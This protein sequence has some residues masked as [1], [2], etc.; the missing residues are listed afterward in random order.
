[1]SKYGLT[2]LAQAFAKAGYVQEKKN[3]GNDV[4]K[5]NEAPPASE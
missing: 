3:P 5:S 4:V 1:M 2:T